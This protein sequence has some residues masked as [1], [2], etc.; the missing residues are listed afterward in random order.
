M[1]QLL[2]ERPHLDD[3]PTPRPLP[4]G[5]RLR[6]YA[7]A[8]DLDTLCATLRDAFFEPW[9]EAKVRRELTE[10]SGLRTIFV[11][12]FGG[13]V[14]GTT[15]SRAIPGRFPDAGYVHWVAV[16][17]AHLRRGLAAAL[18]GRVLRD[19]HERGDARAILETDDF[20]APAITSYLRHGF[21]PVYDVDGEDHR[22]RWSAIFQGLPAP[23]AAPGA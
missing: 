16:A 22:E 7:G 20:R 13:G 9:D 3:L 15:T 2:M 11:V 6:E 14:V 4:D 10:V 21:L 1:P 23:L 19:F 12:E 5:Y 18:L 8:R 17:P